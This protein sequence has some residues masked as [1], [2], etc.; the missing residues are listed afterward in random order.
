MH[1]V[2]WYKLWAWFDFQNHLI[3]CTESLCGLL[4]TVLD[5]NLD[6]NPVLNLGSNPSQARS[7]VSYLLVGKIIPNPIMGSSEDAKVAES[8]VQV[9]ITNSAAALSPVGLFKSGPALWLE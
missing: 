4:C 9:K 7:S 5:L 6:L 2:F 1:L 3:E 8:P